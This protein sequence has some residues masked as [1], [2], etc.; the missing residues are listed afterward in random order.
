MIMSKTGYT[1]IRRSLCLLNL[2][3]WV[4]GCSLLALGIWLHF[5]FDTYNRI[6]PSSHQLSA[7]NLTITAGVLTI[8]IAFLGCC[9]A[10]FQSKCVLG[11]F[12]LFVIL[13]LIL[14][15]IAGILCFVF[16]ESING[17]LK[18]E[19]LHGIKY[20]YGN[21]SEGLMKTWDQIQSSLECCGVT[22]YKDWYEI[23]AWPDK[24]WVPESCCI[25]SNDTEVAELCG[26]NP[27]K[28]EW[29]YHQ[30]GCYR[31]IMHWLLRNSHF[32]GI[33][34]VVFA[35]VQ[36]FSIVSSLLVICTMDYKRHF[37][38]ANGDCRSTYNRVPT[39]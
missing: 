32:L 22:D 36:F 17:T 38:P 16:R 10:W 35:F 20:E 28:E 3:F 33:I 24:T 12:L 18:Q 27:Q 29:K 26:R 5:G 9:G 11:T 39:L 21:N 8:C 2:L 15:L 23:K 14:Q 37:R 1:C 4:I 30:D 31:K 19:M 25:P 6:L 13:A 34:C 7:D